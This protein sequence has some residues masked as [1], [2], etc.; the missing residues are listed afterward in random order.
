MMKKVAAAVKDGQAAAAI[1][2][3]IIGAI[4]AVVADATDVVVNGHYNIIAAQPITAAKN[5]ECLNHMAPV[6]SPLVT[7]T[8]G[9]FDG[10]CQVY[11]FCH[12]HD[13]DVQSY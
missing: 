10:G 1:L 12:A 6:A 4:K 7:L 5:Y 11:G 2:A 8:F 9:S 13:H 3:G